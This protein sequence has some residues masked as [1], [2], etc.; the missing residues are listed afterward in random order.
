MHQNFHTLLFR[1]RRRRVVCPCKS[2]L[3]RVQTR[4]IPGT[5]RCLFSTILPS[6]APRKV[7]CSYAVRHGV[8]SGVESVDLDNL[9]FLET[10]VP[11]IS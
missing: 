2:S 11:P 3:P 1:V 7:S 10:R 5:S 9:D 4:S 6:D 8:D